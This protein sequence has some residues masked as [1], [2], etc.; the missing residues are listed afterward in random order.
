MIRKIALGSLFLLSLFSF[1]LLFYFLISR[2][3]TAIIFFALHFLIRF[4]DL[5]IILNSICHYSWFGIAYRC[6]TQSICRCTYEYIRFEQIDLLYP[7]NWWFSLYV[8]ILLPLLCNGLPFDIDPRRIY[9]GSLHKNS[10][11][12][13]KKKEKKIG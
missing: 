2:Y 1:L 7:C 9:K 5:F 12:I 8:L 13:L 6:C 3:V 11:E 4:Y 10:P